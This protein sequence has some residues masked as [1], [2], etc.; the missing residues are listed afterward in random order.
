MG[1][2]V[3]Y[4]AFGMVALWLLGEVLLQYKARLRWRVLAFGGFL[5]LVGG[6]AGRSVALILL[7]AIA[8]GTGQTFV[9]LSYKRG[10][11]TGWAI[12]GRPSTSRRRRARGG[13]RP[14]EPVLEVGPIEPD[15]PLDA[16]QQPQE[17]E[18][19]A[20]VG[21]N[22]TAVHHFSAGEGDQQAQ[23][24]F[25]AEQAVYQP[26][27]MQDDS[28]EYP[29]YGGQSTYTP[30]PYT[31]GGYEGYGAQGY[32]SWTGYEQQQPAWDQGQQQGGGYQE[33]PAPAAASYGYDNGG[34]DAYGNGTTGTGY[35]GQGSGEW[36]TP[37]PFP[38]QQ[39]EGDTYGGYGYDQ[40]GYDQ[41]PP[42]IPQQQHQSAYEPQQEPQQEYADPY[43]P[44]RY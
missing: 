30:D 5:G 13:A 23:G 14:A 32:E 25:G 39:P 10:F 22:A 12:G 20:G 35:A 36:Q 43:D 24:A 42:Y 27:P 4:I 41:Q 21:V 44:Y 33:Q 34:Y 8:F 18:E 7:G 28:G 9:T 11:S 16:A 31:S 38:L 37:S 6:V 2:S 1:Y 40:Q 15:S 3:L 17:G 19:L 26:M 29:L